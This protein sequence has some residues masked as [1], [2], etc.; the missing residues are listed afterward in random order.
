MKFADADL[1]GLLLRLTI[2]KQGALEQNGVEAKWRLARRSGSWS[3]W[4][5][6]YGGRRSRW[7]RSQR[8]SAGYGSPALQYLRCPVRRPAKGTGERGVAVK[9]IHERGRDG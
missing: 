8:G 3:R 1:I 4:T 2:S 5:R 7:D 6:W 9:G